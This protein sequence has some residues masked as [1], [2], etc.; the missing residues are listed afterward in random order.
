MP[1]KSYH[2]QILDK[3]WNGEKLCKC[4]ICGNY[5]TVPAKARATDLCGCKP[6]I[7]VNNEET[8]KKVRK[9]QSI[10]YSRKDKEELRNFN[11]QNRYYINKL[12]NGSASGV[13][14][15]E[16]D[17]QFCELISREED[18]PNTPEKAYELW[19][20]SYKLRILKYKRC[21]G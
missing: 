15:P 10:L 13:A 21:A 19:L 9:I 7:K 6:K 5:F 4:R 12:N 8:A 14:V 3:V 1:K 11:R 2:Q 20:D 16:Y 17:A 18:Y